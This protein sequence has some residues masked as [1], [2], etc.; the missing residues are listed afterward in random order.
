MR[1]A[2]LG[3]VVGGLVV[4]VAV[5]PFETL[6]IAPALTLSAL[7]IAVA[8]AAAGR[9]DVIGGENETQQDPLQDR[10]EHLGR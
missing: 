4:L 1:G 5:G 2:G 3:F 6:F 7:V 8:R 9:G 10:P